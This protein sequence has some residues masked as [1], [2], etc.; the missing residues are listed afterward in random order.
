MNF[1]ILN[2]A[3]HILNKNRMKK[4]FLLALLS[5]LFC[6]GLFA[7]G[8]VP[9]AESNAVVYIVRT[10][11]FGSAL[12]FKIFHDENFVGVFKGKGYMRFEVPAGEQ[13]LWTSSENKKFLNCDFKPGGTYII[14][15]MHSPGLVKNHVVLTPISSKH[16]NFEKCKNEIL[17][18]KE[19]STSDNKKAQ[20]ESSLAKNGFVS[21]TLKQY[22][23]EQKFENR[24]KEITSNMA[25]PIG[26][27]Q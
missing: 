5:T 19:I 8:F 13:L 20:I 12:T 6:S 3:P 7:Q 23:E 4:R 22:N 27:L 17:K 2:F 9:P 18:G 15:T 25:I 10:T 26:K 1:K 24:T 16:S 14:A 11:S 21:K